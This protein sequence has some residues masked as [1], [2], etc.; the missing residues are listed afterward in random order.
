MWILSNRFDGGHFSNCTIYDSKSF[1]VVQYHWDMEC[2][3]L[4][5]KV[6]GNEAGE[7]K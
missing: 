5:G 7:I 2:D 6:G 4:M 3:T 1:K